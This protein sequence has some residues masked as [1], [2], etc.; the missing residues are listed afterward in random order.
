MIFN[1][2]IRFINIVI[3]ILEILQYDAGRIDN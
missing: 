3:D 2:D 1:I